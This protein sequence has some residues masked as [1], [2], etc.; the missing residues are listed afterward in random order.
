MVLTFES[1]GKGQ[2]LRPAA[3][4]LEYFDSESVGA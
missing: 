4:V 3:V 2:D 1:A